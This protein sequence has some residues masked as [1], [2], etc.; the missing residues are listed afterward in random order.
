MVRR[1]YQVRCRFNKDDRSET[2]S[3]LT[4]VLDHKGTT[5]V[6][7]RLTARQGSNWQPTAWHMVLYLLPTCLDIPKMIP[8]Y[9]K[10]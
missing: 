7:T 5:L 8:L 4:R 2:E 9:I 6:Q 1:L 3:L 10:W